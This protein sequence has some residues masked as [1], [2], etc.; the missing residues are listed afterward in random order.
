MVLAILVSCFCTVSYAEADADYFEPV[1]SEDKWTVTAEDTA[2]VTFDSAA[3]S[4][5]TSGPGIKTAEYKSKGLTGDVIL[6][7]DAKFGG[8]DSDNEY[9]NLLSFGTD[10]VKLILCK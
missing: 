6:A 9:Y 2:T 10:G 5:V 3:K 8:T 7:F 1:Y 4:I